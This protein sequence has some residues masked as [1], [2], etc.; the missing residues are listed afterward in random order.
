MRHRKTKQES[1]QKNKYYNDGKNDKQKFLN[2][3]E[4]CVFYYSWKLSKF[5]R[6]W[7]SKILIMLILFNKTRVYCAKIET[8]IENFTVDHWYSVQEKSPK[9]P[10]LGLANIL[11]A[12]AW[13][14]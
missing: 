11:Q 14:F 13:D 7:A 5:H 2:L 12:R 9:D 4:A 6:F 3:G 8:K 10:D 1:K